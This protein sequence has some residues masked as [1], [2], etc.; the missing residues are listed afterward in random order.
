M[1][2]VYEE[3]LRVQL[4]EMFVPNPSSHKNL[5]ATAFALIVLNLGSLTANAQTQSEPQPAK[6]RE[7]EFT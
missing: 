4:K 5:F 1:A 2:P 6:M 3:L 7:V